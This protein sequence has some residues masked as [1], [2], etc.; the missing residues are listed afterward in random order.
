[1]S[2]ATA[3]LYLP[4]ECWECVLYLPDECWECVFKFLNKDEDDKDNSYFKSLS[5]VSKQFLSITNRLRFS[6]VIGHSSVNH[7]LFRRFP[8]ITSINLKRR[9]CDYTE[10]LHRISR[11]PLKLISLNCSNMG[12]IKSTDLLLIA[13]CFP[14]LKELQLG[15]I[16]LFC[17]ENNYIDEH[18]QV[19]IILDCFK[20]TIAGIISALQSVDNFNS[21]M[22]VNPKLKSLCLASNT[23]L[24]DESI[25]VLTSIFP[26]LQLLDL[27]YCN[28]ISQGICQVLRGCCKITH[29]NLAGCSKV[30]LLGM[31]F[32]A[33]KLE[34]LSLSHTEVNDAELRVISKS[35]RGLLQ[36]LLQNCIYVSNTGVKHVVENCTRLREIS[37]KGCY[38]G[39]PNV[40]PSMILSRSS[41]RKIIVPPRYPFNDGKRQLLIHGCLLC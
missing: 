19:A 22:V 1:M 31:S 37:L 32:E 35:C 38:K 7:S 33:P 24:S 10:F 18:L 25:V 15:R 5:L 11:F 6:I 17:D 26:N 16:A 14:L 12:S 29:L 41:L 36:L 30:N 2:S 9:L 39:H 23:R 27:S 28:K 4:D 21:L 13:N 40:V 8:N 20:I 3:D 34:M